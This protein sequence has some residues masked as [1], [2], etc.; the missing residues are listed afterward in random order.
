MKKTYSFQIDYKECKGVVKEIHISE[1]P[2]HYRAAIVVL[3]SHTDKLKLDVKQSSSIF[4]G[5]VNV[6]TFCRIRVG[7][8]VECK[9]FIHGNEFIVRSIRVVNKYKTNNEVIGNKLV[10][11][12]YIF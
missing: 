8:N 5:A 4:G 2:D 7:D 11:D 3:T 10:M 9:Y 6:S 12:D 1:T